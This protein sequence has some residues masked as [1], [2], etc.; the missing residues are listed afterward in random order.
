MFI[1]HRTYSF[2]RTEGGPSFTDHYE[3]TDTLEE[4]Q[5]KVEGYKARSY[6]PGEM[7]L[8]CWSIAEVVD[9]SEPHWIEK[10][11]I[12]GSDK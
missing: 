9:A 1:V 7:D 4:A 8:H 10:R 12:W 3:L 6:V 11:E 5:A 2:T